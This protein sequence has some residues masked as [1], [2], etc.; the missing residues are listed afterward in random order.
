MLLTP[1]AYLSTFMKIGTVAFL[2][3]GVMVVN[4]TLKAPAFKTGLTIIT[5]FAHLGRAK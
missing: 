5:T 3:V 2:I 1:R 4:P